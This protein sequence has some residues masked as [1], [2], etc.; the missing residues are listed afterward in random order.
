MKKEIT[1]LIESENTPPNGDS[2]KTYVKTSASL[3]IKNDL[4]LISYKEKAEGFEDTTT[5]LKFKK[6][7]LEL[8]RS[9]IICSHIIFE[10]GRPFNGI[11]P[12]PYGDFP[13]TVTVNEMEISAG[14]NS[15]YIYIDYILDL[16]GEK[17]R[18]K[19]N[20]KYKSSI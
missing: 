5:T 12:T 1:V 3:Y 17:I 6:G 4:H 10:K 2:E 8:L 16:A 20:L 14:D 19:F 13:I 9:G 15:G 18:N 11:Y 7:R